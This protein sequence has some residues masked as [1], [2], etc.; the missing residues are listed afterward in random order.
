VAE[1]NKDEPYLYSFGRKGSPLSRKDMKIARI[2]VPFRRKMQR[3]ATSLFLCEKR[4]KDLRHL[5]SFPR[6]GTKICHILIPFHRKMQR[7]A[8][9][10]F[11]FAERWKD[12]PHLDS[13]S[14]KD[15]KMSHIFAS[16]DVFF[17]FVYFSPICWFCELSV[18]CSEL[19]V[20]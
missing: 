1:R 7:C 4:N 5:N 14:R 10:L 12:A 17:A 16:F 3:C 20:Q 13:F 15:A 19:P 2:F 6:K 18:Q 11:L 8:T 9:S